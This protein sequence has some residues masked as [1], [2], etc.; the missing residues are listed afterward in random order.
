MRLPS[1]Y[2]LGPTYLQYVGMKN[3]KVAETTYFFFREFILYL[4]KLMIIKQ[5]PKNYKSSF[6]L[7]MNLVVESHST[8]RFFLL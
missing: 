8:R 4:P 5:A 2:L 7:N 1:G 3:V 6:I